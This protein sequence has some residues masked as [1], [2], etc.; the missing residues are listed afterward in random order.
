MK[1]ENLADKDDVQPMN[2][3]TPAEKLEIAL[4]MAQSL[5]VLHGFKDGIIVH[6]D[7]Q[8]CQ[9]LRNRKNK[10]VLGD[11]NR[12][13]IRDWNEEKGEYCKHSNGYAYGNVS[14]FW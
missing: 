7:V 4:E 8:L 10:L 2:D 11:F 3:Y 9:W 14:V 13:E 6:D 12:A 1:Q 5:T